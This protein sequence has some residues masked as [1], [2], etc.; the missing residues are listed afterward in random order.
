MSKYVKLTRLNGGAL[1]IPAPFIFYEIAENDGE[2]NLYAPGAKSI[3]NGM[4]VR[5]TCEEIAALLKSIGMS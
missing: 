2:L 5:E 3:V 4:A 1:Y